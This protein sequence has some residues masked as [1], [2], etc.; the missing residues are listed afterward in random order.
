MPNS[1]KLLTYISFVTV[2]TAVF[3]LTTTFSY[4]A[5]AATFLDA[6]F[7]DTIIKENEPADTQWIQIGFV[8]DIM[9]H[10]TQ[11]NAQK[12]ADG[13]YDFSNNYKWM[14]PLFATND[15][16]IGN[17][18]T[19]F[20]GASQGYSAY[21]KFNTPDALAEALKG[22]NFDV[23]ATA[24]NHMYDTGTKGLDRTLEVLTKNDLKYTGSR[25][26]ATQ[27][28][29]A[30]SEVGNT[31]VGVL[32]YTYESGRTEHGVI[33][34][35][36]IHVK[37]ADTNRLNTFDPW[38]LGP[39]VQEMREEMEKMKQDSVSVFIAVMHWGYEYKTMPADYQKALADSL[40]Q[41]GFHAVFGS[42]PHVVQPMDLLVDSISGRQTY[43]LYS[44]GNFISNQRYETLQ[45]YHTEDGVYV[46]LK[47]Q[48]IGEHAPILHSVAH[49]P[50][51]VNR[52]KINGKYHYEVMPVTKT[53]ASEEILEIFDDAQ[54]SRIKG[55]M[56]R[57]MKIL[58]TYHEL[59]LNLN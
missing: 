51:W 52:Y 24:N 53:L 44:A 11:L 22:A 55:S 12:Q 40:H 58:Q 9:A 17:L 23:L 32:A 50:T 31:K 35:N 42:H 33:T 15:V 21:P 46:E 59:P 16:M 4:N 13:S 36:G 41:L 18:E 57:T 34:I 56:E 3:W 6:T 28:R 45:N 8:G 27:P 49:E 25:L 19:T 14:A 30:I 48:K 47:F 26:S 10:L 5:S 1:S 54:I 39:A 20:A 43:V 29:Y 2:I 38:N 37:H 7:S